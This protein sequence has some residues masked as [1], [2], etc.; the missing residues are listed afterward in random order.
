[1]RVQI[2]GMRALAHKVSSFGEIHEVIRRRIFKVGADHVSDIRGESLDRPLPLK[3]KGGDSHGYVGGLADIELGRLPP[4]V[5]IKQFNEVTGKDSNHAFGSHFR[6]GGLIILK[7][8]ILI[9]YRSV[10]IRSHAETS[11]S[12]PEIGV[13]S[14][15]WD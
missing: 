13:G 1:M 8:L 15:I 7:M 5:A 6:G 4:L 10:D 2:L 12:E 9:I 3:F 14:Q 11:D